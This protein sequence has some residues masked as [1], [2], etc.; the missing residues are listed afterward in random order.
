VASSGLIKAGCGGVVRATSARHWLCLA[1]L[2]RAR[3]HDIQQLVG[4]E[5]PQLERLVRLGWAKRRIS[6]AWSE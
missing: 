6:R 3:G 1:V 5:P 4:Q 2:A